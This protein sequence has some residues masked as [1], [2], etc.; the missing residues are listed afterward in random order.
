MC[1]YIILLYTFLS[2]SAVRCRNVPPG[3]HNGQVLTDKMSS[4][5]FDF[6]ETVEYRCN[7]GYV[8]KTDSLSSSLLTCEAWSRFSATA[9]TCA[10]EFCCV[11]GNPNVSHTH[12]C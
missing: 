12:G 1:V 3:P 6:G 9:P 11:V 8:L 10:G 5:F 2:C 4:D 7:F